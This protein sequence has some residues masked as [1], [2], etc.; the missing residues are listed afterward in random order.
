MREEIELSGCLFIVRPADRG[1][2]EGVFYLWRREWATS[3]RVLGPVGC[4]E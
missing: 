1:D 2:V 3:V 4:K